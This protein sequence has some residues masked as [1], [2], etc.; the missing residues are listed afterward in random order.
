MPMAVLMMDM[1][2]SMLEG[3]QPE[4]LWLP[5]LV[6]GTG[7]FAAVALWHDERRAMCEG[8]KWTRRDWLNFWLFFSAFGLWLA[9]MMGTAWVMAS[10]DREMGYAG[11][12][13]GY[14]HETMTMHELREMELRE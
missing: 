3:M 12:P 11:D 13:A 5:M 8:V 9:L 10:T 7:A 6:I 2:A 4:D 14:E 1:G